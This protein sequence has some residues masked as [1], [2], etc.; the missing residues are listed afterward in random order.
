MKK[1][2]TITLALLFLCSCAYMDCK[3]VALSSYNR[4]IADGWQS[5]IVVGQ[6]WMS[7]WRHAEAQVMVTDHGWCYVD[8]KDGK[9]MVRW[10]ERLVEPDMTIT[11]V[12]YT[13]EEFQRREPHKK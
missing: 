13:G 8:S 11:Q 3:D 9:P 6:V 1:I 4:A 2:I 7:K 10:W 5:R 12:Y